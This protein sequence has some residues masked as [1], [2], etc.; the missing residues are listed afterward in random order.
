M[1]NQIDN[2]NLPFT[3]RY[4]L[5]TILIIVFFCITFFPLHLLLNISKSTPT[6]IN[7]AGKQRMLSQRI[8]SL[9]Q[10]YYLHNEK[11]DLNDIRSIEYSLTKAIS[12]MDEGNHKLST[13]HLDHETTLK[14]SDT[15]KDI[16]FGKTQLKV[17]IDEYLHL[18]NRLMNLQ[19]SDN[20]EV[21][22]HEIILQSDSLL[23]DL[24]KAVMQYQHEGEETIALINEIEF[25]IWVSIFFIFLLQII[26]L[27]QPM[28]HKIHELLKELQ[29]NETHLEQEIEQRMISLEQSNYTLQQL[30]SHDPLTGLKN[31][32]NLEQ[33]LEGLINHYKEHHRP[34]AVAMIDIDWFKKI[35]DNYGH[36]IGDVVLIELSKLIEQNI[37]PEDSAYRA[38]GEE[39]VII[40]NR[41]EDYK[42]V[43]KMEDLRLLIEEHHFV[44][45]RES[46]KI[47][48]S[49]GLYHPNWIKPES[50]QKVLKLVDEALY[51]AKHSGRNQIISTRYQ[52][53]NFT[54]SIASN[55]V[56][57]LQR[58]P[59]FKALYADFDIIDLIGYSNDMLMSGEITF[60]DLVY[61]ED[62]DF[63]DR[64][65]NESQSFLTTI[66][67]NHF[68][69][70]IKILKI[71]CIVRDDIWK[72]QIQDP[73]ALAKS[74]EE[75]M[76]LNNFEAMM[77]NSD[78]FI[79]FKD[80]FHVFTAGSETL[81]KLTN[82]LKKED[83]VGKT[84]YEVFP[85]EYAD[86]YFVLEKKVFSGEVDVASEIQPYRD[87]NGHSGWV[88][89]R[90]YPIKNSD[91][92]IIGL[93]GIARIVSESSQ[94][95]KE[96]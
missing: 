25:L 75:Q 50:I 73:I 26:F 23:P 84:D 63:L 68:L 38:G 44:S 95:I 27:F 21:I 2:L 82:V 7:I 17:R 18:V 5:A 83:L 61:C 76:L 81:L 34:F 71:E 52:M 1:M 36:D 40:F 16:Y 12:D 33:E 79:Y 6:L 64:L 89:N 88:D 45:A 24:D 49:G 51:E 62:N 65:Q 56:I 87:N 92:E 9:T 43:E 48:I 39:F 93:F 28:V 72:I 35:N 32:L 94:C 59:P 11:H 69:G 77:R 53:G 54:S 37:R 14:L 91:G 22:A 10:H 29:W 96:T 85:R 67:I 3:K 90:K 70:H 8:S 86:H 74:V 78:D 46:L 57:I 13:G 60:R 47:T 30:A 41:I 31:R 15:L 20:L 4:L 55:C 66:R 19:S 58:T 80:R 42:A